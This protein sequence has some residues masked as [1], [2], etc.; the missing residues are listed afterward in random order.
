[1]AFRDECNISDT[2]NGERTR[3]WLLSQAFSH[4][5]NGCFQELTPQEVEECFPAITI[6]EYQEE[7]HKILSQ[8][9]SHY[10]SAAM[11]EFEEICSTLKVA[12]GLHSLEQLSATQGVTGMGSAAAVTW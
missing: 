6:Q 8:V 4:T 1:M 2:S 9:L 7:L 12:A 10:R 5:V 3:F 11:T